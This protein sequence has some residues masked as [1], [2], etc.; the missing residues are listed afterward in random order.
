METQ[1]PYS[2]DRLIFLDLT[3]ILSP[4]TSLIWQ[5]DVDAGVEATSSS[6]SL[7]E[8]EAGAETS[9]AFHLPITVYNFTY[10]VQ[11]QVCGLTL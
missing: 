3:L 4:K 11:Y 10:A 5:E 6:L 2:I 7:C 9:V 1:T 8:T